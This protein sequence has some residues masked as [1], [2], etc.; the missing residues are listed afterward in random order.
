MVHSILHRLEGDLVGEGGHCGWENAMYWAAGGP[1]RIFDASQPSTEGESK[2]DTIQH[3]IGQ[4]LAAIAQQKCPT[5]FRRIVSSNAIRSHSVLADHGQRRTVYVPARSWD[6]FE[7]IKCCKEASQAKHDKPIL[8]KEVDFLQ[9]AELQL[10][11]KHV[12]G[13]NMERLPDS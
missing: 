4:A 5:L 1:K 11:L 3:S 8:R 12:M 2:Y 7:W 9:C 10:I 6:P 13:E